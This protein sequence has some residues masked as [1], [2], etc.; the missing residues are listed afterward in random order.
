[1]VGRFMSRLGR[2]VSRIVAAGQTVGTGLVSARVTASELR[3]GDRGERVLLAGNEAPRVGEVVPWI[4]LDAQTVVT[5]RNR[6]FQPPRAMPEYQ[7]PFWAGEVHGG[8]ITG[9][10]SNGQFGNASPGCAA[11][12]KGNA[13][14][15]AC[16]WIDE[17]NE[18]FRLHFYCCPRDTLATGWSSAGHLD[19][20]PL[21]VE[22]H[23]G[24]GFRMPCMTIEDDI[25]FAWWHGNNL[26][27]V[28]HTTAGALQGVMGQISADQFTLSLAAPVDLDLP[29][30]GGFSPG[31][32]PRY[33]ALE[34]GEDGMLWL[35]A[36]LEEKHEPP[37]LEL[38][39]GDN[40]AVGRYGYAISPA[41][42][43]SEMGAGAWGLNASNMVEHV[44]TY[45]LEG[46]ATQSGM[47]ASRGGA[48]AEGTHFFMLTTYK[49]DGTGGDGETAGAYVGS[50]IAPDDGW[51]V[52]FLMDGC[53]AN[54]LQRIYHSYKAPGGEAGPYKLAVDALPASGGWA[55]CAVNGWGQVCPEVT[56]LPV[57]RV[58]V[59]AIT[60]GPPGTRSRKIYRTLVFTGE[61]GATGYV[62]EVDGNDDGAQWVDTTGPTPGGPPPGQP[63]P[64]YSALVVGR[65]AAARSWGSGVTWEVILPWT[66]GYVGDRPAVLGLR[67][68]RAIVAYRDATLKISLRYCGEGGW[69]AEYPVAIEEDEGEPASLALFAHNIHLAYRTWDS[70]MT[71]ERWFYAPV[72]LE[73]GALSL[74]GPYEAHA[75]SYDSLSP[76]LVCMEHYRGLILHGAGDAAARVVNTRG[77]ER[78]YKASDPIEVPPVL[79]WDCAV[80][81]STVGREIWAV[82]EDGFHHSIGVAIWRRR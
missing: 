65:S 1:M 77:S 30:V 68:G 60:P 49:Q 27:E 55:I 59:K 72:Q 29:V 48:L 9:V 14:A 33:A 15:I 24:P 40:L 3:L 16:E 17:I 75:G 70:G 62:G 52:H 67:D 41:S 79:N 64:P 12:S 45:A 34:V 37:L 11:D 78:A 20:A 4:R 80:P 35:A 32:T 23:G 36:T 47:Y 74:K 82:M 73:G 39:Y 19:F 8:V 53:R 46:G 63:G 56:T 21:A 66:Q 26:W 54:G 58:R 31:R 7:L 69:G 81:R 10:F 44:I 42:I 22:K 6:I 25:L 57:R 50:F 18:V 2:I 76:R 61:P 71:Q 38:L 51:Q 28:A 43:E 13:W 5:P